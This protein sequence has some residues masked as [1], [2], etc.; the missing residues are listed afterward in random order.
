M[1]EYQD[2][3]IQMSRYTPADVVDNEDKQDHFREGLIGPIKYQLM[4]HTF[5]NF[6]KMVDNAILAERARQE[7][8]EQKRKFESTGQIN[9]NSHPHYMPPQGTPFRLG[10]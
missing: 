9:N 2:K 5:K 1:S 10:G 8:G 3:F 6:Q 4:V 7:M